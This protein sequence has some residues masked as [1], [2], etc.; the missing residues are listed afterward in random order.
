MEFVREL[1][2]DHIAWYAVAFFIFCALAWRYGRKPMLNWLD[3]EI[4]KISDE[5][6][7]ACQLRIEAEARLA[8]IRKKHAEAMTEADGIKRHAQEEALRLKAQAESDLRAA[9]A[10][11]EQQAADRIRVAETEATATVRAVAVD[12]AIGMA[13]KKLAESGDHAA[14][15]TEQAISDLPGLAGSKARAA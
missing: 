15:L 12:L 1:A 4:I 9:L 8:E 13:R 10:R 7:R 6:A 2:R 5:L 11:H 14:S 3:S